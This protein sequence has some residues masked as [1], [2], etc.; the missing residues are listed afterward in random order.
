MNAETLEKANRIQ[1]TIDDCNKELEELNK[2][3]K[4]VVY[5]KGRVDISYKA[6]WYTKIGPD[7]F[8][9]KIHDAL[10]EYRSV[11]TSKRD[12]L[13]TQFENL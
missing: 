8:A 7:W 6:E 12:N 11:L 10:Y 3:C 4:I 13:Q 5:E 2:G 1:R 9:K